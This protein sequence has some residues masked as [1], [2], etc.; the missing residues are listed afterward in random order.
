MK[1]AAKLKIL[2]KQYED[3]QERIF[4]FSTKGAH[5]IFKGQTAGELTTLLIAFNLAA[6]I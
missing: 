6:R 3:L 4:F 5:P 1:I 2:G